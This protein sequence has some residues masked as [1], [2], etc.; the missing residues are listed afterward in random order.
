MGERGSRAPWQSGLS[1]RC[2][3]RFLVQV[4]AVRVSGHD[5]RSPQGGPRWDGSGGF[6]I[7]LFFYLRGR[8][9]SQGKRLNLRNYIVYL[10]LD[11]SIRADHKAKFEQWI[12]QSNAKNAMDLSS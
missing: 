10:L 8:K 6:G 5:R 11:D 1:I 3:T 9:L 7:V 2:Q 12:Q 4:L